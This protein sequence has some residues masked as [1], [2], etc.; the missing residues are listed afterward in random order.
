[1]LMVLVE[2]VRQRNEEAFFLLGMLAVSR[3]AVFT[4]MD[5]HLFARRAHSAGG[6]GQRH[7]AGADPPD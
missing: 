4:G 1:M 3:W 5:E 7:Q 2:G 6:G